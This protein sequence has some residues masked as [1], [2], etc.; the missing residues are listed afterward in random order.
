[1]HF[2]NPE[3]S[4]D[5]IIHRVGNSGSEEGIHLSKT[6]CQYDEDMVDPLYTFFTKSFKTEEYF[7]FQLKD[8]EEENVVYSAAK[9]IFEDRTQLVQQ[10]VN[11]A[12]HL[13]NKSSNPKVRGGEMF[14]VYFPDS[15]VEGQNAQAIG[16][17]KSES[18]ERILKPFPTENSYDITSETGIQLSKVDKGC[19]I[20]NLEQE[21]GYIVACVDNGSK[22]EEVKHWSDEFLYL[23]QREDEFYDTENTLN[24]CKSYVLDKLPE[25]FEV[26]RVDQVD[27]LNKSVNFF[28]E[29]EKFEI[30]NFA[31]QVLQQ[32]EL[33]QSFADYK[34]Q[35]ED[36]YEMELN[37]HFD[38][39]KNAV[40]KQARFFKSIIKLDKNFHI[41]VH[42]NRQ[43][44]EQG[45]DENGKK[46]Y[47]LYYDSEN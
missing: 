39:S 10:S 27:L 29:N 31:K 38:I 4:F 18:K 25:E 35:F 41:Y 22:T 13:Y 34:K 1:M 32:D 44:I 21:Q 37:D 2:I 47:K 42:G 16:I 17:F 24:L 23:T 26:S 12:Y 9:A 6:L 20:F 40:K 3:E 33:I 30:D 28:K 5:L 46:Y 15:I 36:V 11:L 45:I 19:L 14:V 7:R 8:G 43:L